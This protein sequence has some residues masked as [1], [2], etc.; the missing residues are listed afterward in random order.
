[1][2]VG[3]ETR[4]SLLVTG[5]I[6]SSKRHFV[7][8]FRPSHFVPSSHVTIIFLCQKMPNHRR[9]L[10]KGAIVSAL[11]SY[12]HPS[13]HIRDKYPNVTK[14]QRLEDLKVLR[15]EVKTVRRKEVMCIVMSHKHF[16]GLELYCIERW[17]KVITERPPDYFFAA[18]VVEP[19]D[20][21][22]SETEEELE[23][24]VQAAVSRPVDELNLVEIAPL[25]EV[26]NDNDPV[27]EN[28]PI[29][30]DTGTFDMPS[31]KG[32]CYEHAGKDIVSI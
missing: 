2:K 32:L 22:N 30:P 16:E 10:G 17:C 4:V 27:P 23:H 12:L 19:E 3:S 11:L 6:P 8:V 25:V 13:K 24:E 28:L 14:G 29:V 15:K 7:D 26:D 18:Q 21:S 9:Q 20:P 1:M 31:K 5:K